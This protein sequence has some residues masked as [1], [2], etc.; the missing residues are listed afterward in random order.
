LSSISNSFQKMPECKNQIR[1]LTLGFYDHTVCGT[2]TVRSF[3]DFLGNQEDSLRSLFLEFNFIVN[4]EALGAIC[5]GITKLK[6]LRSLEFF[7]N[8]IGEPLKKTYLR[9]FK[10]TLKE[11]SPLALRPN[12]KEYRTWLLQL[13][14]MLPKIQESLE[15]LTL[16]VGRL[17]VF[18][19]KFVGEYLKVIESLKGMKIL[20]NLSINVPF[21]KMKKEEKE[22]LKEG[23]MKLNNVRSILVEPFIGND[24]DD[25]DEGNGRRAADDDEFLFVAAEVNNR[26]ARKHSLFF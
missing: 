6:R 10:E 9:F 26:Q 22:K 16:K 17:T 21:S 14:K 12:V 5:Q 3:C 23:I 18:D 15:V 11:K 7:V 19:E 1:S 20:K 24:D 13:A 2:E 25:G 4:S 8:E